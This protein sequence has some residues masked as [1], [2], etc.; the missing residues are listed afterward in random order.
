[1]VDCGIKL[2]MSVEEEKEFHELYAQW[3]QEER[4]SLRDED[5]LTGRYAY[6]SFESRSNGRGRKRKKHGRQVELIINR[7]EKRAIAFRSNDGLPAAIDGWAKEAI[8]D[9]YRAEDNPAPDF[10]ERL[11]ALATLGSQRR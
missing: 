8:G 6:V 1:M 11:K 3:E 2:S 5:P 10:V 9:G 4:E 7:Q